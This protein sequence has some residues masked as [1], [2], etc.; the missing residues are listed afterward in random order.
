MHV[1]KKRNQITYY[2]YGAGKRVDLNFALKVGRDTEFRTSRSR[3]FQPM[4]AD[5][6][7]VFQWRFRKRYSGGASELS[8]LHHKPSCASALNVRFS[9]FFLRWT[10]YLINSVFFKPNFRVSFPQRS[11]TTASFETN[12]FILMTSVT[13]QGSLGQW[14]NVA[15]SFMQIRLSNELNKITLRCQADEEKKFVRYP[16]FPI[17]RL[18]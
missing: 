18:V 16:I 3:E 13:V 12:P 14:H 15:G 5:G 8:V 17:F 1:L 10:I 6:K 7:K 2:N 4:I 11:S 9:I